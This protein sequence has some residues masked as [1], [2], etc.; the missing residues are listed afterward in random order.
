MSLPTGP[1]TISLMIIKNIQDLTETALGIIRS[2]PEAEK[3]LF[4]NEAILN[5]S[6]KAISSFYPSSLFPGGE[7]KYDKKI[8]DS[9]KPSFNMAEEIYKGLKKH[10]NHAIAEAART[11]DEK[12]FLDNY[13]TLFSPLLE[14]GQIVGDQVMKF[15]F[16]LSCP[17]IKKD[18][19]EIVWQFFEQILD[20]L[21]KEEYYIENYL[22]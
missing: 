3:R 10:I 5:I 8:V 7:F 15:K 9:F 16:F 17:S 1:K 6:I 18:D 13:D 22:K 21:E 19:R 4:P 14:Q 20:L 11:R 12:Y 2:L